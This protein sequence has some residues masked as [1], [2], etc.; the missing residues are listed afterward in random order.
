MRMRLATGAAIAI[1][2]VAAAN[3]SAA[4]ALS[5]DALRE[6]AF[7]PK[8]SAI[9][10][11]PGAK[12]VER[13]AYVEGQGP[14]VWRSGEVQLSQ[15]TTLRVNVGGALRGRD[16][17][18]QDIDVTLI[19]SWPSAVSFATDTLEFEVSPHAGF[20][21]SSY[22]GQAEAGATLKVGGTRE[23]KAVQ[24]LKE[25]GVSEG[26]DFGDIGRWYLFAAASGRAVGFNMLRQYGGWDPSGW[27]T[28]TTG[29]LVGDAQI[30][31]CWR[32]GD[33]QSSFGVI[34][35]EVRGNHMVFG[36]MTRDDTVAAFTFSFR[37]SP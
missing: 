36:Q 27:T 24:R 9:N 17:D 18:A 35:R 5:A 15:K 20:G 28:D 11:D 1:W 3:G 34:H 32:K 4:Q 13:D 33:M 21:V 2:G 19:R 26:T 14:I 7:A 8:T 22:G 10:V 30:G 25:M 6:A 31:V 23:A 16:F 37:P 12:F 29:A